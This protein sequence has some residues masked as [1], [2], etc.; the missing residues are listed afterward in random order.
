M[1]ENKEKKVS[2]KKEKI[3]IKDVDFIE[4]KIITLGDSGVGKTSI[5]KRFYDNSFN[6]NNASTIGMNCVVKDLYFNK[7]KVSLKLVDTCGQEKYRAL[8]KSYLKNVNAVFFVFAFND[9]DSFDN[10]NEWM[11]FFKENYRINEIPHILLGNKCDLNGEIDENIIDEYVKT[12]KLKYI[13]TS[14]KDNINIKE[15]FEEL[16]RMLYQKDK[17]SNKQENKFLISYKQ[18]KRKHCMQCILE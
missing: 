12:N 5:I 8:T 3:K 1:A 16:G 13:K 15:S 11:E 18:P 9:K 10:I 17:P 14:A 6:S 4:F 2:K 7:Q